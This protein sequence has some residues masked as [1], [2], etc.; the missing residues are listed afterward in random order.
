MWSTSNEVWE[1]CKDE[2]EIVIYAFTN[3]GRQILR[4]LLQRGIGQECIKC[5]VDN[6]PEKAGESYKGINV[7][8]LVQMLSRHP[9]AVVIN[10]GQKAQ[11]EITEMLVRQG[12]GADRIVK[13]SISWDDIA[14]A[15]ESEYPK[16]LM[17]LY[18]HH[19]DEELD[20][21]HPVK[22]SEKIQWIKLYDN[23]ALKTRLADKYQVREWIKDKVGERYLIPL[24]GV[25]DRPED[26]DYD[27]L[28][29]QFVLKCNH[30]SAYVYVVEDKKKIDKCK[31]GRLLKDWMNT[32]FAYK[33]LE[34]HYRGI[35]RKILAEQYI[36]E[37]DGGLTDYKFH[38]FGGRPCAV[39]LVGNRDFEQHTATEIFMDL[40]WNPMPCTY[41]N[42]RYEE[43]KLKKP[44]TFEEMVEIAET[45]SEGFK[46]VRVDLYSVDGQVL[47]GEMTFT[48]TSGYSKWKPAEYDQYWGQFIALK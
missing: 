31:I 33:S 29:E 27:I 14:C 6:S 43:G 1:R 40:S 26:V 34:L 46:Y 7:V 11:E 30:G 13:Y 4:D 18:M 5:F 32:E 3:A 22:F 20:L 47:F 2:D 37:R 28:P 15:P 42:A 48:P 23:S 36:Q 38:C 35:P 17:Q 39:Q 9:N 44:S 8:S 21:L 24:L 16:I 25:W 10:A 41:T 45:L 19:F 12:V